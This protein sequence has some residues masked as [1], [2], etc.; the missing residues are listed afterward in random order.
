MTFFCLLL[1]CHL[2][3]DVMASA[4][5]STAEIRHSL[6]DGISTMKL[7]QRTS[8][9]S[10]HARNCLTEF[11]ELFDYLGRFSPLEAVRSFFHVGGFVR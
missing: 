9:M 7:I 8:L 4:G 6:N 11:L 2:Y 10:R 3:S 5:I 1:L